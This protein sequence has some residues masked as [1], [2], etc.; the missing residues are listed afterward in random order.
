MANANLPDH[1]S[2]VVSKIRSGSVEEA[3]TR[4]IALVKRRGM[5][6]FAIVD[7]SGEAEEQD[8]ELRD[9]KLVIFGSPIAGTPVMEASPL[10][11]LELPL[12]VLIWDDN[13]QTTI[14]YTDP[15]VL[16][17]RH[18]LGGK[19]TDRLAGVG[20]LTDALAGTD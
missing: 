3:V 18:H 9:T 2:G 11:A 17:R 19:L 10:M 15:Y 20:P 12:K 1:E 7:H 8:L 16:A 6:V 4:L 5:K 13:G 14:S